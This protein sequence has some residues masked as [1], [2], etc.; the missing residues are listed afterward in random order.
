MRVMHELDQLFEQSIGESAPSTD[1]ISEGFD[2]TVKLCS[3][4]DRT[5]VNAQVLAD[6]I[7]RDYD[8]TCKQAKLKVFKEDGTDDDLAF[9]EA[10]AASGV[11][12]SIK[13]IIDKLIMIWQDIVRK[14]KAVVTTKM[15]SMA[16]KSAVKKMKRVVD[17]NPTIRNVKVKSPD[18][19]TA[20]SV[21]SKYRGLCNVEDGQYVHS[22]L[23]ITKVKSIGGLIE[24]FQRDFD[25]A[26]TGRAATCVLT[27]AGLLL[28]IE[29]E[30]DALP[31]LVE[32]IDMSETA[33]IRRLGATATYDAEMGAMAAMQQAANFRI[34]LGKQELDSHCQ[35]LHDMV[36][37][38]KETIDLSLNGR[39]PIVPEEAEEPT[40]MVGVD[41]YFNEGVNMDARK[42][43]KTFKAQYKKDLDILTNAKKRGDYNTAIKKCEEI[44]KSIDNVSDTIRSLPSGIVGTVI[45]ILLSNFIF[46]AKMTVV[47]V[48]GMGVPI[49]ISS[50]GAAL[51]GGDV[52]EA[53][54]ISGMVASPIVGVVTS[55][56]GLIECIKRL[57]GV[58][59]RLRTPGQGVVDSFNYYVN[60]M[61]DGLSN[62]RNTI[63]R[64]SLTCQ[65]L[66][67]DGKEANRLAATV[68]ED[69]Q[70]PS[71][72]GMDQY[73]EDGSDGI[74]KLLDSILA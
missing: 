74:D 24:D 41:A 15:C 26:I 46:C 39:A 16:A 68:H 29:T 66:E 61:L 10:S 43:F 19:T 48:V 1:I 34:Q 36:M 30:M 50:A 45:G 64:I 54:G 13:S 73:L 37:K 21:I 14:T 9:Y 60:D 62:M 67:N 44:E 32:R 20:L 17:K 72:V 65:M 56:N 53:I 38:A 35:Y 23:G 8:L 40:E 2:E 55:T 70:D 6:S 71:I 59:R 42:I 5:C 31:A 4:L 18:I 49:A 22:L 52:S 28:A 47:S 58:V 3:M 51:L 7:C 12:G 33:I 11:V 57:T 69:Y 63:E 27:L 25:R